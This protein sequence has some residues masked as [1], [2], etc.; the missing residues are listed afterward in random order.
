MCSFSKTETPSRDQNNPLP[1]SVCCV[2]LEYYPLSYT[3]SA[4]GD[5]NLNPNG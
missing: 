3:R 2:P 1:L 5:V 4:E